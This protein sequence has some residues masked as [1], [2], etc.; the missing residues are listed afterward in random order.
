MLRES[1]EIYECYRIEER[2]CRCRDE[3]TVTEDYLVYGFGGWIDSTKVV[4]S[5][6]AKFKQVNSLNVDRYECERFHNTES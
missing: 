3:I 1:L 5:K 4:R 6:I 2:A